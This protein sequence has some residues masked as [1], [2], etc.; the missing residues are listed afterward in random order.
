M[1][2]QMLDYVHFRWML[3]R[4]E[5]ARRNTAAFYDKEL[6]AARERK[7]SKE[8][9]ESLEW[10]ARN[11]EEMHDAE[12]YRLYTRH[13]FA[14]ARRLVI[15]STEWHASKYWEQ[16]PLGYRHLTREGI[17]ELRAAIRTEKKA[18]REAALQWLPGVTGILGT[19]IGLAAIIIG[20][21]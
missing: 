2:A 4:M 15:A 20:K 11:E 19:L 12:V 7:A 17:S 9:L 14:E 10:E 16:S 8:E 5:R 3:W 1:M 6:D 13:L 21:K 18:A